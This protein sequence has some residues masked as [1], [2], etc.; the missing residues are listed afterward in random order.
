MTNARGIGKKYSRLLFMVVFLIAALMVTCSFNVERASAAGLNVTTHSKSD[1]VDYL[2]NSGVSINDEVEFSVEPVYNT[3]PGEMTEECKQSALKMLNCIRYVAGVPDTV[4]LDSGYGEK[5]Q[6]AA[7]ALAAIGGNLTH[8]LETDETKPEGMEN[9]L[10][11][12]AAEGARYSNLSAGRNTLNK[13]VLGWMD[14]GSASNVPMLGHRRWA[15]N[16][17][18]G[19]T[20]FGFA[21]RNNTYFGTYAAEYS[22]DNSGTGTQTNVAWPARYMPIEFFGKNIPWSLS[23]GS[24]IANPSGVTVTLTRQSDSPSGAGTWTFSGSNTYSA[25]SSGEYFNINNENYGQE[26]CIIFRPANIEYKVG[27]KFNVSITGATSDAINY[28]VEFIAGYPVESMKFA[29]SEYTIDYNKSI[30]PEVLPSTASAYEVTYSSSNESVVTVSRTGY[31]TR[32]SAGQAT[33]T[34]TIDGAYTKSGQPVSASYNV[35]VPKSIKDSDVTITY[36]SRTEYTGKVA[37]IGVSIEYDGKKLIEGRDY[38]VSIPDDAIKPKMEGNTYYNYTATITGKG[39]YTGTVDKNF[40]IYKKNLNDCEMTLEPPIAEYTGDVQKPKVTVKNGDVTLEEGVDYNITSTGEGTKVGEYTVRVSASN[41]ECYQGSKSA[42][43]EIT[44]KAITGD[45]INIAETQLTYDGEQK[46]PRVT[47]KNGE[48]ELVEG[49][50]YTLEY[51]NNVNAGEATVTVTGQGNYTGEVDKTFTITPKPLSNEMLELAQSEFEYNRQLQKPEVNVKYGSKNL[52]ENTDYILTNN[53]GTDIGKYDVRIE[54]KGNYSGTVV[55]QFEIT[56]KSLT[57]GMINLDKAEFIYNGVNQKPKVTVKNGDYDLTSAE[58]EIINEGG[59]NVGEYAVTVRAKESSNYKGEATK[60]YSIAAKSLTE[61]MVTLDSDSFDYDGSEHSPKVTVEDSDATITDE[62]YKISNNGGI[63]AGNYSVTV[64]GTGNYKGK[65]SKEY[66]I[67]PKCLGDNDIEAVNPGDEEY[68]GKSHTPG[69]T[70]KAD[71]DVLRHG[72]DYELTYDNNQNVGEAK[73]SIK[74][75]GNYTGEISRTFNITAKD[76]NSTDISVAKIADETYDGTAKEPS[77]EMSFGGKKL[78]V[79]T[80]YEV[81]YENNVAEGTARV[82]ITGKGNYAGERTLEFS[83]NKK[84]GPKTGDP[85]DDPTTKPGKDEPTPEPDPTENLSEADKQKVN[86]IEKALGVDTKTAV[87]I[88]DYAKKNNIDLATI[89]VS[90]KTVT[91]IKN[92]KDIKGAKFA[93]LKP[94]I[95][96]QTKKAITLRWAKVNGASGYIVYGNLCSTKAKKYKFKKLATLKGASKITWTHEKLKKGTCYKY[97]IIA[98][99]N[100]N[101][102]IITI[103]NAPILHG[104]TSGG[105][106]CVAKSVK[107]NKVG[108]KKK[109]TKITLNKG[110]KAAI[111]AVEVKAAKKLKLSRHRGLS[112][113]TTNPKVATVTKKGVIRAVK[114]GKCNIYVYAQNGISKEIKVTVK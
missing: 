54:G 108:K 61:E 73:I 67:N 74:F 13:A 26:G 36:E 18:M 50:D 88:N 91:A 29:Q 52:N 16:P 53:G 40:W 95:K 6:A 92:D 60:N 57:D 59:I 65:V 28:S 64:E 101:G 12:L 39:D 66:T 96:K 87:A 86:A 21:S 46:T 102:H 83:I 81:S 47:V 113:E 5:A 15:I 2:K 32:V 24:K 51:T 25:A 35:K 79:G 10:W 114:K 55:K 9:S 56:K 7:F 34:A 41:T 31:V 1:V 4:T 99:R 100:I 22:F 93:L 3:S 85:K 90:D 33:I 17:K 14:D 23:V 89:K 43:F 72:E 107:I 20:G 37:D 58:C 48:N 110:K 112:Y 69:I 103:A 63:N 94:L 104:V 45:M 70:V 84:Q 30:T 71:G 8:Y 38:E 105:K 75:K 44:K 80:D 77:V 97:M 82:I 76:I 42:S 78:V 62:D 49:T 27:D 98:Y 111:K 106:Y 68:N 19:K 11:N 109:A